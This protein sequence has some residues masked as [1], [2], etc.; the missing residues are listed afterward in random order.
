[1][2]SRARWVV[3]IGNQEAPLVGAKHCLVQ[4]GANA[5]PYIAA[6]AKDLHHELWESAAYTL[7]TISKPVQ[8]RG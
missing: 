8:N 5:L 1:M 4:K 7:Q 3:S 2:S 6:Y